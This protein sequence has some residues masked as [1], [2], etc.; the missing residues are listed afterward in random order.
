MENKGSAGIGGW[1]L[2]YLIGSVPPLMV[3][4]MGLSGWFFEYPFLLMVGIFLLL[5]IPLVLIPLKSPKA[6]QW[7]IAQLWIIVVLMASR[8]LSVFLFPMASGDQPLLSG[9]ELR[10]V[11]LALSGI[12]FFT[13]AWATVW[14]RYFKQSLRVRNT[15]GLAR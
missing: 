12:V 9:E 11:V 8:A 6:P 14:T 10:G 7:N 15:F 5:A 2:F 3:Y 1:L 13:L 4:S